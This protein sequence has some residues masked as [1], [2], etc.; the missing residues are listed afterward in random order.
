MCKLLIAV[1]NN[2][3]QNEKVLKIIKAQEKSLSNQPHG[4]SALIVDKNNNISVNR[5]VNEYGKVFS[6]V[7]GKVKTAKIISI[8]T[9]QATSGNIDEANT[10]FFKVKN[11]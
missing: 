9:R 6:W 2:N 3:S 5:T 10:H 7:Y 8:H 4:I 11:Y 1:K